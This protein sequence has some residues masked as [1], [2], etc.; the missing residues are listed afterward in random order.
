MRSKITPVSTTMA[1]ALVL[2]VVVFGALT[3]VAAAAPPWTDAPGDWWVAEYGVTDTQVGTVAGGFENG[4]FVPGAPVTRAQFAKMV[5]SGLGVSSADPGVSTFADVAKGS[6]FY[7]FAE[8]ASAAGLIEGRTTPTG[9]FFDPS[10]TI[11]RQQADSILGRYLSRAE[12]AATGAISGSGGGSGYASLAGWYAAEGAAYLVA[13]SDA[14]DLAADHAA[15]AAYLVFHGVVK[16]T[17]GRLYPTATLSRAQAAVLVLRVAEEAR[18]FVPALPAPPTALAVVPASPGNDATPVVNGHIA[19]AGTVRVYDAFGGAQTQ[20][21]EVVVAAAGDFSAPLATALADGS[22]VFTADIRTAGGLVGGLHSGRL[23][24]RYGAAHRRHHGA[25]R[26]R[27]AVRRNGRHGPAG[28]RRYCRRRPLGREAGGVPVCGRPERA[29]VAVHL[30][31]S[32][33]GS[34]DV[35]VCGGMALHG[36][37]SGGLANGRYVFR[38]IVT[39]KA[40]NAATL[41]PLAV[42]VDVKEPA[43]TILQEQSRVGLDLWTAGPLMAPWQRGRHSAQGG[44]SVWAR[45]VRGWYRAARH[46]P[47]ADRRGGLQAHRRVRAGGADQAQVWDLFGRSVDRLGWLEHTFTAPGAVE[48]TFTTFLDLNNN[49]LPDPGELQSAPLVTTFVAAP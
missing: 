24:G 30:H 31:R 23:P 40:G 18:S 9:R 5:V 21:A 8:G 20:V 29:G 42:T 14:G 15:A 3:G 49:G 34:G 6:V 45:G 37:S 39:D 35:L 13:F 17:E 10:T 11:S 19:A 25:G 16:G 2:A 28:F 12:L 43:W 44:R 27:R 33:A 36:C 48:V 1:F 22:H 47:G 46:V 7:V 38:A 26:A 4:T 32:R 41:G